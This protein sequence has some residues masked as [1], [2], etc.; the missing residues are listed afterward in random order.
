MK[1]Y[2]INQIDASLRDGVVFKTWM[3]VVMYLALIY[4]FMLFINVCAIFLFKYE[5]EDVLGLVLS[6]LFCL[7]IDSYFA[8]WIIKKHR[9]NKKIS[10][11]LDDAVELYTQTYTISKKGLFSQIYKLKVQFKYNKK[12][13]T[14]YSGDPEKNY[15]VFKNHGYFK[16]LSKYA[17]KRVKILYSPTYN[18]VLFLKIEDL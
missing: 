18:E 7:G 4:F 8:F 17:D 16:I 11:W 2:T 10:I 5:P 6:S 1:K 9:L 3:W 13:Y 12:R 15:Y 14:L